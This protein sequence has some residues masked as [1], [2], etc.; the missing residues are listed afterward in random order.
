M[1]SPPGPQSCAL[2]T[3]H[4]CFQRLQKGPCQPPCQ[5]RVFISCSGSTLKSPPGPLPQFL[6]SGC[7]VSAFS[8]GLA[9][10]PPS[11]HPWYQRRAPHSH[12]PPRPPSL[13][14]ECWRSRTWAESRLALPRGHHL[15]FPLPEGIRHSLVTRGLGSDLDSE[16]Y[17]PAPTPQPLHTLHGGFKTGCSCSCKKSPRTVNSGCPLTSGS[18]FT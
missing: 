16:E 9:G 15:P 5:R 11:S 6:R 3:S 8:G 2:H 4:A 18:P 17:P 1:P 13:Q 14:H 7:P 12:C 10:T